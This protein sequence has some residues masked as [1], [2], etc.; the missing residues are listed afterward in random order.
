MTARRL[1]RRGGWRRPGRRPVTCMALGPA[2]HGLPPCPGHLTKD[3]TV[4]FSRIPRS[5][6]LTWKRIARDASGLPCLARQPV[7]LPEKRAVRPAFGVGDFARGDLKPIDRA[8]LAPDPGSF[9]RMGLNV[10]IFRPGA[11]HDR[12]WMPYPRGNDAAAAP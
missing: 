9:G 5:G 10:S 11:V 2:G 6:G 1:R 3:G 7:P 8:R 12:S 4:L